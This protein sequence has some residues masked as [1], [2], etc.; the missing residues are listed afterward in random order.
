M[1]TLKHCV[2][3]TIIITNLQAARAPGHARSFCDHGFTGLD[4]PISV[5]DYRKFFDRIRPVGLLQLQPVEG[6]RPGR[7]DGVGDAE[8]ARAVEGV[9]RDGR[10]RRGCQIG[11]GQHII[12]P[13]RRAAR[14]AGHQGV[15]R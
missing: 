1:S 14:A 10:P 6:L 4:W 3:M 12:K 13:V 2:K 9:G 11:R 15:A 8:I 7:I 5:K